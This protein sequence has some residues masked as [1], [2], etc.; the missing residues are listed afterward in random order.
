MSEND[1]LYSISLR[2]LL[3]LT[4]AYLQVEVSPVGNCSPEVSAEDAISAIDS[5]SVIK[6]T[7]DQL[8][9]LL[10][11]YREYC[12]ELVGDGNPEKWLQLAERI[13]SDVRR[14]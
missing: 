13:V 7:A 5:Q 8:E 14:T 6:L 10:Y 1:E 2:D 3:V 9:N 11:H 12:A 4:G